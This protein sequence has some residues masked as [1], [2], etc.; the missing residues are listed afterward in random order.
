MFLDS[1]TTDVSCN[2][3]LVERR[4]NFYPTHKSADEAGCRIASL[5]LLTRVTH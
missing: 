4:T 1:I 5:F 2:G 3:E